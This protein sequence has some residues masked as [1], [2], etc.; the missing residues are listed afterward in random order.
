M[1]IVEKVEKVKIIT[2]KLNCKLKEKIGGKYFEDIAYEWLEY[3][4]SQIKESSYYNYKFIIEKYLITYF[5]DKNM[6]K[7][8]DFSIFVDELSTNLAPKTIRDIINVFKP[9]L[10]YYEENY[11]KKLKYKKMILPKMEKRE[12]EIFTSREKDKL[13]N[14]CLIQNT[15]KS[16]GIVMCLNTGMRLGELCAL[17]WENIDVNEKSIYIK[18]TVQRVYK[19][20]GVKSKVIID[21]PKTKC[22]IREIPINSKLYNILK[23][24]SKKYNKESF[25]LTGSATKCIEPRNYQALF[26]ETLLKCK[27]KEHNFHSTRHTFATNCIEV[28]MD[29]KTL[30][31]ILGHA[32]VQITL[33]TYV[34]TNK[35]MAKK[36]LEKL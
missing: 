30:S 3:K 19:G 17:K 9:I 11:D 13:E 23:P 6:K 14:Y 36:Y 33:N 32:N 20:K 1:D 10:N 31:K 16:L 8:H 4:K 5:G 29:I 12:I 18:E 15:L 34:H 27:I 2:N 35:K 21:T 7:M 22:S 28:G 25:F 24:L 26:K